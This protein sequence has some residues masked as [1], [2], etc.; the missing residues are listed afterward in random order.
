[1]ASFQRKRG[2]QTVTIYRARPSVDRRGNENYM[3]VPD[4][5]HVGV[6]CSQNPDRSTRAEVPGQQEIDVITLRIPPDLAEVNIWS[7]VLWGERWYDVIAPPAEHLG[8]RHTRHWTLT[9]RRR[10]DGGGVVG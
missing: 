7:Q 4:L 5:P 10:P 3:A 6:K 8:P 2:G 9:L 1:M